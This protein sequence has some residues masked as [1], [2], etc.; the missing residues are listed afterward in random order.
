MKLYGMPSRAESARA[1]GQEGQERQME[2]GQDQKD[3]GKAGWA[4]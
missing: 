1:G 4:G 2:G 3:P